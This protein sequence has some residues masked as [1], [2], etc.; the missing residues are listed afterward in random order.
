M[1]RHRSPDAV[2]EGSSRAKL[3]KT[4]S[5]ESTATGAGAEQSSGNHREFCIRVTLRSATKAARND[6]EP[7]QSCEARQ[8]EIRKSPDTGDSSSSS[9]SS[10]AIGDEETPR[11]PDPARGSSAA[12]HDDSGL[13]DDHSYMSDEDEDRHGSEDR[14]GLSDL[15][16]DDGLPWYEEIDGAATLKR[17]TDVSTSS[18]R[19]QRG[20]GSCNAKLIRRS[21]MRESFWVEMEDPTQET[22]D[23]AFDLFDR[24][25]R[26]NRVFYDHVVNKGSGVWGNELDHGDLLLFE[27]L[28]VGSAYR[29][30][31]IGT[32][33]VNAILEKTRKKVSKQV[34]FF[35]LARPGSLWSEM[36]RDNAAAEREAHQDAM[37]AALGFWHSM[38]FRRVGT[39]PWLA[40]T[41]SPG[42][43]SRQLGIAQDCI[44]P[45]DGVADASYSG[46]ME[47]TFQNLANPAVEA[48]E[49]IDEIRTAFPEDCEDAQW[50]S[51]DHDGNTLLHIAS[52]SSKPE[53]VSFILSRASHLTAV[54]NKKGFTPVEALQNQLERQRT[55]K[56]NGHSSLVTSDE[57]KG[58]S[59]SSI[60]CLA[61]LENTAAFDLS[62]LSPRDIERVWAATDEQIRRAPQLDVAGMRKTMR[63]KYG[64]TCGQCIGGFLSPRMKFVLLCV[65]DI[66]QDG[67]LESMDDTGPDW[68]ACNWD[69]LTHLP[70]SVRENLKTNKSMREG[71]TSMV[72]HF[73]ECLR[74]SRMPTEGEVLDFYRLRVSEWPPVTRNYLQ[75]GG[76]VAAVANMIFEKA[77]LQDE[78]AGDGEHRE[79]FGE[80][81][82]ELAVCRNDHE[83]GFVAGMCGYKRV[84]P[85]SSTFVDFW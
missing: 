52:M 61:A 47:K 82:D 59:A 5:S 1:K 42:H 76:S 24:Y 27:E 63:Y 20:I 17:S 58:F 73:A 46:E 66:E 57:F 16:I 33:L 25:G 39:S 29:R 78:W 22:H 70:E 55:R 13:H 72:S 77:M 69:L 34:G 11:G 81:I 44:D 31:G 50:Q 6:P 53:L 36:P 68:V 12:A 40:W 32:K 54:R 79:V 9:S 80:D 45:D 18:R 23:L 43:P 62:I 84:R 21:M 26:L 14:D 49:C 28:K 83:F 35:A 75:R 10:Q 2:G 56:S 19:A 3:S 41:D 4:S 8:R 64:C 30:R 67:M 60:A 37:K 74:R 65:S 15:E 38:G 51:Y 71:F 48:A 85:S 7:S